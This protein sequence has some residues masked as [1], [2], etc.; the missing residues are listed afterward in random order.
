MG[1]AGA[2]ARAAYHRPTPP[3]APPPPLLPR[4]DQ[5][6]PPQYPG[7]QPAY[8]AQPQPYGAP[9]QPYG[10]PPPQYGAPQYG[11]PPPQTVIIV[12]Q[13]GLPPRT[14]GWASGEC[15]MCAEPGGAGLCLYVTFCT[16]CA[17]GDVAAAAGRDYLCSCLVGPLL[18]AL[19]HNDALADMLAACLW[20]ADRRALAARLGVADGL[21]DGSRC[22]QAY[23]MFS[24][25][26][27]PCLLFQQ[28]NT[29]RAFEMG[30]MQAGGA[31]VMAMPAQKAMY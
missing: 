7:A 5:Q 3:A 9:P 27:A 28:L 20:V 31:Q 1:S 21:D 22:S 14:R 8:G 24:C 10:A 4:A 6:A 13:G 11:A 29:I 12:Q 15:D 26:C 16:P 17:A 19:S 30:A 25:G 18:S 23:L 2:A